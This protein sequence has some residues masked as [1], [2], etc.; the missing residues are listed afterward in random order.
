MFPARG[1]S[2]LPISP[3]AIGDLHHFSNRILSSSFSKN[4]K[5]KRREEKTKKKSREE[6]EASQGLKSKSESV[7]VFDSATISPSVGAFSC[8]PFMGYLT[9][10][11]MTPNCEGISWV[12][13]ID[14]VLYDQPSN[15]LPGYG[16]GPEI[17]ESVKQKTREETERKKTV[18]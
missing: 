7:H 13:P 3:C 6:D 18:N 9:V 1:N 15:A 17:A 2:L 11:H 10:V 12:T 16:I 4:P 8:S 5:R 14:P